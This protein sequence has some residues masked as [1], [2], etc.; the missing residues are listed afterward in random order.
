MFYVALADLQEFLD[1]VMCLCMSGIVQ[2]RIRLFRCA[3]LCSF[4]QKDKNMKPR[5]K[6]MMKQSFIVKITFNMAN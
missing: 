3:S 2:L 5:S 1:N 4:H 6:A